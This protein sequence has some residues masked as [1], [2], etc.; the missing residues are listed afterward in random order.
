MSMTKTRAG[1][2]E[3]RE[4][5]HRS[6]LLA[7]DACEAIEGEGLDMDGESEDFKRLIADIR[8]RAGLSPDPRTATP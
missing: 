8:K 1:I 2:G 5:V 3:L 4:L 7:M 6:T